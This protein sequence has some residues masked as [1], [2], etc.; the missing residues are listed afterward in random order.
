MSQFE[1]LIEC[2]CCF[3]LKKEAFNFLVEEN[4]I[5]ND[6]SKKKKKKQVYSPTATAAKEE[7]NREQIEVLEKAS[8]CRLFHVPT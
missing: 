3:K 5:P 2:C 8:H 7:F 6:P 1:S 4:S